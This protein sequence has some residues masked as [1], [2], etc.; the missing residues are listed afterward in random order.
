MSTSEVLGIN[1]PVRPV[2]GE[3]ER[4]GGRR[5]EEAQERG[6]VRRIEGRSGGR[7]G[8]ERGERRGRRQERGG[9]ERKRRRS[10]IHVKCSRLIP[11]PPPGLGREFGN[12]ASK[13]QVANYKNKHTFQIVL[14]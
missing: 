8:R 7:G 10:G 12:E 11:R 1:S 5:K 2:R 4:G 9:K 14:L 13:Q 6:E 3:K